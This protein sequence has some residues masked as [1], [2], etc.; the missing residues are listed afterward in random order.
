MSIEKSTVAA[1]SQDTIETEAVAAAAV[2]A[3]GAAPRMWIAI[4][5]ICVITLIWGA[6]FTLNDISLA[7]IPAMTF[8]A[9]AMA[10]GAFGLAALTLAMGHSLRVPRELFG[11][12]GLAALF[13]I[14][15]W[16]LF[17]TF[18]L[19]L[20]P[21]GRA[22]V[23]AYMMPFWA[24][25]LSIL[26]LREEINAFKVTGLA[27]GLVGLACLIGPDFGDIVH[28]PDG[29]ALMLLA[30]VSWAIGTV[31]VKA[32]SHSISPMTL[33]TWMVAISAIP[34][35]VL[36]VTL[37]DFDWEASTSAWLALVVFVIG[38]TLVAQPLWYAIVM[39][40]PVSMSSVSALAVPVA[41]EIIS[42]LAFGETIGLP[43]AAAL[44]FVVSGLFV[45]LVLPGLRAGRQPVEP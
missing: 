34:M 14:L 28:A 31:L 4:G 3:A 42:A 2:D 17:S 12:I 21:P 23:I 37:E 7:H 10:A 13:N 39:K 43:E 25:A 33:T 27:L 24:L 35:V 29:F 6:S 30:S 40:L 19:K 41:G 26:V 36:A 20:M 38:S 44:G 18:G 9:M 8:R 5:S 16:G 11:W 32:R 1:Q 45:V 15:L 22:A